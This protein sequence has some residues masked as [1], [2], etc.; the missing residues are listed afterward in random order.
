MEHLAFTPKY[1]IVLKSKNSGRHRIVKRF[2]DKEHAISEFKKFQE[3]PNSILSDGDSNGEYEVFLKYIIDCKH[4]GNGWC[5]CGHNVSDFGA[6][7]L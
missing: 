1:A 7:E 5:N 4:Y 2:D 3:N 6:F